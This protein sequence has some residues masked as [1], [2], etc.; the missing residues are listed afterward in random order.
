LSRTP[1]EFPPG[2]EWDEAKNQINIRKHGIDFNDAVL[3]F[4][5]PTLDEIDTSQDYGEVRVNSIG[6]LRGQLVA[7]V[8]HTDRDGRSRL[9]SARAA[10]RGE[11][12]AYGR[13]E[14]RLAGEMPD[15]RDRTKG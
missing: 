7:T 13:F 4:D 9:I 3:V 10:T 8:T 11:R 2:F 15:A 14:R 1:A 12:N 6:A 5:G